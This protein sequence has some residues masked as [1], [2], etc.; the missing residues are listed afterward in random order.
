MLGSDATLATGSFFCSLRYVP[1]SDGAYVE[2][3]V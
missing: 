3:L 2:A 1:D